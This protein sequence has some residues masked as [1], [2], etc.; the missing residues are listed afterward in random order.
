MPIDSEQ[1][2]A[3]SELADCCPQSSAGT[4]ST[5]AIPSPGAFTRLGALRLDLDAPG[6]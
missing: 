4:L 6:T 5:D 1:A 3:A 2:G